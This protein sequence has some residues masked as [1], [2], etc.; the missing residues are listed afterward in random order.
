MIPYGRQSL[1]EADIQAVVAALRSDFLTTG[2]LVERFEDAF[3][4]YVGATSAVAVSNGTAALHLAMLAM[5]L[6]PGDRVITSPNTFLASANC[7]AYAGG[8]PDFCDINSSG[9][10]DLGSL[11]ESW[12]ERTRGVVVVDYGGQPADMKRISEFVRSKGGF[13]IEDASHAVGSRFTLDG[14][15]YRT[16][17]HEW[18][19]ATTF[20]FHP[21][22]TMTTGEGGMVTTRIP[23]IADRIRRLRHHGVER[24]PAA[25]RVDG[26]VERG[27]WYYEM[28][29]LGFNYRL[30]DF[31]CALGLSQLSKL[32]GFIQRRQEIVGLYDD[33]FREIESVELP[34]LESWLGTCE[35]SS[36]SWH[37]YSLQVDFEALEIDR[38]GFMDRLRRVGIG[39]QVLYIP[40]YLQPWY[41]ENFGYV[42]GKCR[43]AEQFYRKTL[44]F[45]LWNGLSDADV[46]RVIRAVK[47]L[48]EK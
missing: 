35:S 38:D 28:Q 46:Q 36:I 10:M 9:N 26:V 31:Q 44:S 45:P 17:G 19:D 39:T 33:G 27:G 42:A 32:D 12:D 4:S 2:P 29:E 18:A 37:L 6:C 14:V 8:V 23:E 7:I 20:S 1:D 25:W 40:V 43:V 30:T 24:N 47:M 15:E 16:G 11:K 3:G 13:V 22:K 41:R 5:D 34:R 48:C 21:V